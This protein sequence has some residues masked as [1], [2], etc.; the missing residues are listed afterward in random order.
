MIWY[1][2]YDTIYDMIYIMI[3]DIIYN[4]ISYYPVMQQ[5]HQQFPTVTSFGLLFW[6]VDGG[7]SWGLVNKYYHA[8]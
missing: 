1:G 6:T 8:I 5:R 2:I 3:Y 4:I 7:V